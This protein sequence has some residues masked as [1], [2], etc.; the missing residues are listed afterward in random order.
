MLQHQIKIKF[1]RNLRLSPQKL[2]VPS[3]FLDQNFDL[4]NP[5][6]FSQVFPFLQDSIGKYNPAFN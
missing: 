1:D 3:I 5:A 2:D 6:T 4:S